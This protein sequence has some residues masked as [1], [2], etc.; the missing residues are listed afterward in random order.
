MFLYLKKKKF[1]KELSVFRVFFTFKTKRFFLN[2]T[3]REGRT[4][5]SITPGLFLKFLNKKKSFKKNR[6]I[7]LLMAKYLRK[8]FL[9]VGIRRFD[10]I[11]RKVP[12]MLNEIL[13]NMLT[14]L[15]HSFTN[16]FTEKTI[17]EPKFKYPNISLKL[18]IF[19]NN[20]PFN[21]LKVRNRGRIKRKI[22]RKVVRFN[23][24][25]D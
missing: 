18:L 16:P 17:N 15:G 1:Y 22:L 9:I 19:K 4:L 11:I 2:L 12:Y 3:N 7:V 24:M 20:K 21:Y 14:P 6:M 5:L 25:V 23:K 13:N 8:V 10:G